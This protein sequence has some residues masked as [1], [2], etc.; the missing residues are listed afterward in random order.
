MQATPVKESAF[1]PPVPFYPSQ[2]HVA[3]DW[4]PEKS[5]STDALTKI[6]DAQ[7]R[8]EK[9]GVLT[10]ELGK[11]LLPIAMVEGWGEGMGVKDTN[12]FYAS[13]RFVDSLSKMGLEEGVDYTKTLV[14]GEPHIIPNPRGGNAPALA[15]AILG[16]KAK[17]KGVS[18]VADA[19]KRYNGKG[20]A[21]EEEGNPGDPDYTRTPADVNVYWKKVQEAKRMLEHPANAPFV[22]A[23]NRRYQQ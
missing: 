9:T 11:H 15:A 10:P 7:K 17:L 14:K 22:E 4:E 8:A 23:F 1:P 18:T 2:R 16:E 19:I 21:V 3:L 6:A 20:K 13:R 5:I 12:A